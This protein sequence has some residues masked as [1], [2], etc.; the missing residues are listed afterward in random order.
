MQRVVSRR[1][2]SWLSGR[3][4]PARGRIHSR[5]QTELP[6]RNGIS[7]TDLPSKFEDPAIK[8]SWRS[9]WLTSEPTAPSLLAAGGGPETSS[10]NVTGANRRTN[11][12]NDDSMTDAST[13]V[14]MI[15]ANPCK[16]CSNARSTPRCRA[17]SACIQRRN[18]SLER[19]TRASAADSA[20]PGSELDT[21]AP[22]RTSEGWETC[23]FLGLASAPASTRSS[24]HERSDIVVS[25]IG[26][27]QS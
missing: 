22:E 10:I 3:H 8:L 13:A 16:I 20:W 26:P 27:D 6:H 11:R 14:A 17:N 24:R 4:P 18:S 2:I 7:R 1:I 5:P 23:G 21:S 25:G 15:S 9:G 12:T 19:G